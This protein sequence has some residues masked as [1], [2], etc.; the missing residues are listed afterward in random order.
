VAATTVMRQTERRRP[1]LNADDA[2][3]RR[4]TNTTV[5]YLN[6]LVLNAKCA[7]L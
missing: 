4:A 5:Y 1:R 7:Y 2:P 3:V 6:P